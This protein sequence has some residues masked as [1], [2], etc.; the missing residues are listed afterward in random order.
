[1]FKL[2]DW[3]DIEKI[4]CDALSLNPNAI[5]LLKVNKDK[6]NWC[7]LAVN[8]NAIEIF[9]ENKDII[10]CNFWLYLSKIQMQFHY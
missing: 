5:E 4:D 10:Y 3:V 9:E 2:R 8:E 1:M 7:L 6:I